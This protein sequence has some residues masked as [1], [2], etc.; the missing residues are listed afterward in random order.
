M[1]DILESVIMLI[2]HFV[3]FMKN[4]KRKFL[5]EV[6][7]KYGGLTLGKTFIQN[8]IMKKINIGILTKGKL[9]I[10]K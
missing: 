6:Y 9:I 4:I 8:T 7:K 10:L 5:N 2:F 3:K 1:L